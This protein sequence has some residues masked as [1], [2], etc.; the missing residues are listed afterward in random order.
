M[1]TATTETRFFETSIDLSE[2]I[3]KQAATLLNQRLADATDL[4]TQTKF[5]HWNVKGLQFFQL[6]E[7]FDQI[8]EHFDDYA[9]LLAERVT[10]LGGTA[11]GTLRQAAAASSISEYELHAT[12]GPEHVR[13]LAHNVAVFAEYVREAIDKTDEMGDKSTADVFTEISRQVDKD[14]WFLQAHLQ[15]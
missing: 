14:L 12:T 15:A 8:A 11:Q 6:H 9:D 5:A 2:H 10:A 7:L 4:K 1:A 3:R 13:A